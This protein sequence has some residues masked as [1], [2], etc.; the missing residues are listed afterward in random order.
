MNS[1]Q[2][3]Q[4]FGQEM[5]LD[6]IRRGLLTSR[7]LK[8]LVDLGITGLTANPTILEKAILGSTDYDEDLLRLAQIDKK[9]DEI[10]EIL[11]VE[12]VRASADLFRPVF[13]RTN[14]EWGYACLE[15]NPLLAYGTERTI[16]EA[17]RLFVVLDR[18]NVMVKVPATPE[19]IP[20]IRRLTGEGINVNVTL[21][22]SLA[23]YEQVM[24]AYITGMEDL[25]N[26]GREPGKVASVASFFLSRIDTAV[27]SILGARILGGERGLNVLMGKAAVTSAKLAYRAF[28]NTFHGERFAA[29]KAKGARVQRPLWASTGTKNPQYSDV[30]Y[31]EPLIGHDTVNTLPLAT[32][33]AFLDHGRAEDTIELDVDEAKQDLKALEDAGISLEEVTDKLLSDGV[34]AFSDSFENLMARISDKKAQLTGRKRVYPGTNIRVYTL[35]ENNAGAS[36]RHSKIDQ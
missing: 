12:D 24:E 36:K 30:K 33:Y 4:S 17:R 20:A 26:S 2:L 23:M 18:P 25:I 29:L 21:I 34:K 9:P 6:Y 16:E 7:E 35:D 8:K 1:I 3:A 31:V 14:G 15:I 28:K 10:Y 11:A 19:G 27:D 32:I 22:F 13:D 5:W